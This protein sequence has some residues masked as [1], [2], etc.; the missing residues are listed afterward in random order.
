MCIPHFSGKTKMTSLIKVREM[1]KYC[2]FATFVDSRICSFNDSINSSGYIG[3][4]KWMINNEM[5]RIWKEMMP[6]NVEV[7][8]RHSSGGID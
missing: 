2:F 3:L 8:S 5:K 6:S 1:S 7:L 4:K